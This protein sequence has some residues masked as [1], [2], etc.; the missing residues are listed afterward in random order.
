M[1]K[2]HNERLRCLFSHF[3]KIYTLGEEKVVLPYMVVTAITKMSF[4]FSSLR[5][6]I[7][8]NYLSQKASVGLSGDPLIFYAVV[9]DLHSYPFPQNSQSI[10]YFPEARHTVC[11]VSE[12]HILG[13]LWLSFHYCNEIIAVSHF[14]LH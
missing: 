8:R 6:S 13:V 9:Q 7:G 10:S 12:F 5:L 1:I 14:E 2:V 4:I 3:F 11:R